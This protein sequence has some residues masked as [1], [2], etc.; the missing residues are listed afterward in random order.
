MDAREL[1]MLPVGPAKAGTHTPQS[2]DR[3]RGYG[4]RPS[5]TLGRDDKD[6]TVPHPALAR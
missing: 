5:L 6:V 3:P 2:I 4:S 1:A